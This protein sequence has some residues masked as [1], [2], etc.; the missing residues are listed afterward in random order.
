MFL[1]NLLWIDLRK[2]ISL[3][4]IA[5]IHCRF[6]RRYRRMD[7]SGVLLFLL[8]H[9]DDQFAAVI[10]ARLA[11]RVGRYERVAL[12][13]LV[14]L[15][16]GDAE[17]GA[18][19]ESRFAWT[20]FSWVLP[21]ISLLF[22]NLIAHRRVASPELPWM[23]QLHSVVFTVRSA[24]GAKALAVLP[25]DARD[26]STRKR[27]SST[28]LSSSSSS[29]EYDRSRRRPSSSP[30]YESLGKGEFEPLRQTVW[31]SARTHVSTAA[32][33]FA[34]TVNAFPS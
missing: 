25:A 4:S 7:E 28:A 17:I 21:M 18:L 5:K 24:D 8:L 23:T 30:I 32:F 9:V 29:P 1:Q 11:Y 34:E 14:E 2:K 20:F 22:F 3:L 31:C 10:P 13:A 19:R 15:H 33:A 27:L 26:G 12:R 6:V 16:F